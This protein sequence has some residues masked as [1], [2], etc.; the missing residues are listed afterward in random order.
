MNS[1]NS[2][3]YHYIKI[4]HYYFCLQ[5]SLAVFAWLL[6]CKRKDLITIQPWLKKD[7]TP[8]TFTY[9]RHHWNLFKRNV[10]H[11]IFFVQCRLGLRG[12]SQ[13]VQLPVYGQVGMLVHKGYKVFNFCSGVVTKI[14]DADVNPSSIFGEIEQLKKVSQLDFAPSLTKWDM[15]ERWYEE[16]YIRSTI[17]LA[18]RSA[19]SS[20][21]LKAFYQETMPCL[22]TLMSFQS[23]EMKDL[24]TYLRDLMEIPEV[25]RLGT[26]ELQSREFGKIKSFLD[27]MAE[28]LRSKG[29]ISI[30]LVFTHGDFCPANMLKTRHGI[31]FIDWESAENRS[32]LFDLYSCFFYRIVSRKIRVDT[33]ALEIKEGLPNF[34]S[35][36]TMKMSDVAHSLSHFE[37]VYRWMYY[38]EE[39]CKGLVRERT[40]KNLNILEDILGYIGAFTQYEEL[41]VVNT[42]PDV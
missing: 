37:E 20:T 29:S 23:P 39:V 31:K 35:G 30:Y 32:A 3:H 28:R 18:H 41:L 26:E 13:M 25:R 40:D 15:T 5:Q 36:L 7:L 11:L 9:V 21:F 8:W 19:N 42:R 16:E 14:F 27:D 17:P 4:D 12:A 2:R 1:V 6:F 10:V 34:M 24:M 38:V 22:K 33:V